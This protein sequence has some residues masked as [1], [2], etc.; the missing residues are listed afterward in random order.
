MDNLFS[1]HPNTENRIAALEAL[2]REMGQTGGP[3][4]DG[5]IG[6]DSNV[7]NDT[8]PGPGPWA[9]QRSRD[10]SGPWG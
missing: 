3:R 10:A 1:T 8:G 7:G 5:G 6:R 9:Q 2:A 4:E